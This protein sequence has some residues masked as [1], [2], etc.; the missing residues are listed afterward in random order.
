[1]GPRLLRRAAVLLCAGTVVL[2]VAGC[3][4]S[5]GGSTTTSASTNFTAGQVEKMIARSIEPGLAANLGTAYTLRVRC[6]KSDEGFRCE[7]QAYSP[8]GKA[9]PDQHV[10]YMVTCDTKCTWIPIG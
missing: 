5:G 7:Y 8:K 10:V 4:G 3:G 6:A 2:A 9:V 1:M